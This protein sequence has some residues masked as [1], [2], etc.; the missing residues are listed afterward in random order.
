MPPD[1]DQQKQQD[2]EYERYTK[3]LAALVDI[4]KAGLHDH[5]EFLASELGLWHEFK[6]LT[7]SNF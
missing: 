5:A 3:C 4:H 1:N 2:D 7:T 6:E